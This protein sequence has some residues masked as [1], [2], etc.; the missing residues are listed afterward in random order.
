MLQE[1][2]KED[3]ETLITQ[4]EQPNALNYKDKKLRRFLLKVL[5]SSSV[6]LPLFL[7]PVH[8]RTYQGESP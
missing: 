7:Q 2:L 3:K 8:A 4:N 1:G 5:S 6:G